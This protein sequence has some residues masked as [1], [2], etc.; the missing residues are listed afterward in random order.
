MIFLTLVTSLT[1]LFIAKD[2][3]YVNNQ[4]F[5]YG[6]E[7]INEIGPEIIRCLNEYDEH[8]INDL[9]CEKVK[10]TEYLSKKINLVFNFMK[11]EGGV[12]IDSSNKWVPKGGGHG[13]RNLGERTVEFEGYGLDNKVKIGNKYYSLNLGVYLVNKKNKDYEGITDIY[14]REYI[15]YSDNQELLD[16]IIKNQAKDKDFYLG[17]DLEYL[18]YNSFQ[19]ES[20]I[21]SK[22]NE[23]EEYKVSFKELEKGE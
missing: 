17:F 10:D 6:S 23:N 14:F 3:T 13:S 1:S 20:I 9:F 12:Y 22:I 21:P 19:W 11:Q 8:G 15:D 16:N 18:N 4:E 5:K 2:D 7:F